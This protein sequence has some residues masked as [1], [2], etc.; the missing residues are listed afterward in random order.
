M[1]AGRDVIA[2]R[3]VIRKLGSCHPE[4]LEDVLTHVILVALSRDATDELAQ[5]DIAEIRVPHP[6]AR[7]TGRLAMTSQKIRRKLLRL[8][9][10]IAC[11]MHP[12]QRERIRQTR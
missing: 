1:M 12:P 9:P 6:A 7:F 8:K 2:Q 4:R 11:G 5:R 3:A 10:G